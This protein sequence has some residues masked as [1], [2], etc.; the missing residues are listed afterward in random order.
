[1]MD[2]LPV[3]LYIYDI[4]KGMARGM[5]MAL[6]GKQIDGVWHTSVMVYGQEFY[7]GGGGIESCPPMGTILG[8]P[9][10]IQDMGTTQVPQEVFRDYLQELS[11]SAFRPECYHLLEHN[12]NTFSSEV[13]QF[14]TGKDIPS[15]IT[16]LPAEVM[17]TPFGQ[18]LKPLLDSMSVTPEG[19]HRVFPQGTSPGTPPKGTT[20][21]ASQSQPKAES[22]INK[23]SSDCAAH[24]KAD[25]L[26]RE[27]VVFT[28]TV[29]Q[30]LDENNM[31][32]E[33]LK[34]VLSPESVKLTEAMMDFLM[35]TNG[36]L[37]SLGVE[38]IQALGAVLLNSTSCDRIR[39]VAGSLLQ[40]TS[41][42]PQGVEA[43]KA[44]RQHT[45]STMLQAGESLPQH[46]LPTLIKMVVNCGSS[47]AGHQLLTSTSPV[48]VAKV[49]STNLRLT[50][51]LCVLSL[52]GDR[53]EAWGVGAA[54]VTNLLYYGVSADTSVE[55]A[56]AVLQCLTK[57]L[58]EKTANLLLWNMVKMMRTNRE[59]YHQ[60]FYFCGDFLVDLR[61]TF[62]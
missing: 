12:C 18:M 53:P 46:L 51:A 28:T 38:H 55:L 14:L 22:A 2:G 21:S 58:S 7:F 50:T 36:C 25:V 16:S 56:S 31:T 49:T 39:Q 57:E 42:K 1:M 61:D 24:P 47:K 40:L 20:R 30:I 27:P 60:L 32:R 29:Q 3:K 44:D 23:T 52:L 62:K 45:L 6:L 9:D 59:T 54:A 17:T 33:S 5:S 10:S 37:T 15:H 19:G 35:V 48:T 11:A 8:Q 13:C 41:L 34:S 26:D 4:S 43:M